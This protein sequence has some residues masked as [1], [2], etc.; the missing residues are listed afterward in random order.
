MARA[1]CIDA[2]LIEPVRMDPAHRDG[3]HHGE[4]QRDRKP[5]APGQR[6]HGAAGRAAVDHHV[7]EARAEVVED[8]DEDGDDEE[9]AG[10]GPGNRCGAVWINPCRDTTP[11][12][13]G[14]PYRVR[15]AASVPEYRDCSDLPRHRPRGID[16]MTEM[17]RITAPHAH[18][19]GCLA[20][21]GNG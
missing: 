18:G 11:R 6:A 21:L 5:D 2:L 19:P 10:H 13:T 8:R 14:E 3:E 12:P 1:A 9:F 7:I 16:I 17:A 20:G 4:D 15:R